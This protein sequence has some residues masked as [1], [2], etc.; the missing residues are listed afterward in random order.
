MDKLKCD[1][2]KEEKEQLI[3][4]NDPVRRFKRLCADCV[5]QERATAEGM[6]WRTGSEFKNDRPLSE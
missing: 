2:C 3:E 4:Y 1:K 5:E 6:T